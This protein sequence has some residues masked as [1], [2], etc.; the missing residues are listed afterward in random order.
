MIEFMEL[1]AVYEASNRSMLPAKYSA[2]TAEA[3]SDRLTEMRMR[4]GNRR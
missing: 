2:L 3:L 1:L 4:I